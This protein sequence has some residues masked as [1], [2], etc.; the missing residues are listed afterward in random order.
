MLPARTALILTAAVTLAA[1]QPEADKTAAAPDTCGAA[2][3]QS[4]IGTPAAAADFSSV[5]VLRIIPQGSPVTMDFRPD[6]LNVET[7]EAGLIIRLFCG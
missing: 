7:D 6:R 2:P 3:F 4:L 5:E 1:C